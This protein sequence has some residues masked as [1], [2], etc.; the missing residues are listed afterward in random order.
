MLVETRRKEEGERR[1]REREKEERS[2]SKKKKKK[3]NNKTLGCNLSW[4]Y[5]KRHRCTFSFR[6][7]FPIIINGVVAHCGSRKAGMP[8]PRTQPRFFFRRNGN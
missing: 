7:T 8:Y 6:A 4:G 1:K 3:K 2:G 5:E